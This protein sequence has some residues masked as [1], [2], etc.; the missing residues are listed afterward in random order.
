MPSVQLPRGAERSYYGGIK[1]GIPGLILILLGAYPVLAL[2]LWLGHDQLTSTTY[3]ALAGGVL[4]HLLAIVLLLPTIRLG[5]NGTLTS[6][7][8]RK[9]L[10]RLGV[11]TVV[12]ALYSVLA[13]GVTDRLAYT[14]FSSLTAIVCLWCEL[15][16][17][18]IYRAVTA[19]KGTG[20]Q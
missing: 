19:G 7:V 2:I 17:Y 12:C 18:Q 10:P 9:Y 16:F 8:C 15:H 6:E 14:A 13:Y 4:L 20:D 5:R 1:T 3:F 11:I